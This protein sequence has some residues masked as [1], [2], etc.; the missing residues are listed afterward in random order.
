L[1]K[2]I[3]SKDLK[4]ALEAARSMFNIGPAARP[5]AARIEQVRKSLEGDGGRRRYRD[6][7]YASFTGWALEGAL[8][9]CGAAEWADFN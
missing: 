5:S 1:E 6:F 8:V 3:A 4:L 7:N 9:N 2:N